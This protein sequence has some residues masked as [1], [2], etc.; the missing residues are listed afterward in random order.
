MIYHDQIKLYIFTELES[1]TKQISLPDAAAYPEEVALKV[2]HL[3]VLRV[4]GEGRLV[5]APGP[6]G[7]K[8]PLRVLHH[9]RGNNPGYI[10]G[11]LLWNTL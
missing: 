6:R 2:L 1:E 5:H 4:L 8:P 11:R 3:Q 7:A 10:F 9:Y